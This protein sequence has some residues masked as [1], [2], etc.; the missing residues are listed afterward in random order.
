MQPIYRYW[1][2]GNGLHIL[3]CQKEDKTCLYAEWESG[4]WTLKDGTPHTG[5]PSPEGMTHGQAIEMP[6]ETKAKP[7]PA[8]R[9]TS[10]K[11]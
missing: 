1:H 11:R 3:T 7:E 5:L 8:Y 9:D 4:Q 10:A 2:L 6:K